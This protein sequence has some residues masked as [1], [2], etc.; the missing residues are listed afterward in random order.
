MQLQNDQNVPCPWAHKKILEPKEVLR[1][2]SPIEVP[3]NQC[4]FLPVKIMNNTLNM[5]TSQD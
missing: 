5:C 1:Y 3:V 2:L 4:R